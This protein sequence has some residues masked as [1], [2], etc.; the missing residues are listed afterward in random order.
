MAINC[1]LTCASAKNS[2]E[3][4]QNDLCVFLLAETCVPWKDV[5]IFGTNAKR[6]NSGL[7]PPENRVLQLF[8][9]W[10]QTRL[11]SPVTWL[12]GLRTT[13]AQPAWR[14]LTTLSDAALYYIAFRSRSV[15][16]TVCEEQLNSELC[17]P[18]RCRS[19]R[20]VTRRSTLVCTAP[21]HKKRETTIKFLA[22]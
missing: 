18:W 9:V 8:V 2:L 11:I 10:L 19:A 15:W 12:A 6:K 14:R 1:G 17:K 16:R 20:T 22:R 21:K 7:V 5:N 3:H 13:H 4:T